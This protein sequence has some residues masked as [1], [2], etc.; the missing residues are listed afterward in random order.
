MDTEIKEA[1]VT[2]LG[3]QPIRRVSPTHAE[4]KD[5]AEANE[6]LCQSLWKELADKLEDVEKRLPV[7]MDKGT[8]ELASY[9]HYNRSKVSSVIK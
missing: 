9:L 3:G 4:M 1:P 7:G 5:T 8:V 6:V 2:P